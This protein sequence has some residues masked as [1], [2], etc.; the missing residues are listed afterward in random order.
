M[1]RMEG[2][3][4]AA[5]AQVLAGD[6]SAFRSLVER[7]SRTLFRLAFRI[8]ANEQDA[9]DV[10]QES[11]LRAYRKLNSFEMRANFSTWLYRITVN[12]ALDFMR[13]RRKHQAEQ[14]M[15]GSDGLDLLSNL[16]DHTPPPDRL[17]WSSEIQ[18]KLKQALNKLGGKERL[19]FVLRHCE[20][21]SIAEVGQIL[22][23]RESAT[24]HSIFRAVQK[25]RRELR[26]MVNEKS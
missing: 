14:D 22:G 5:V 13:K 10:V 20:G 7:H 19:A 9:E 23:Q 6:Q 24:K 26:P 2:H 3:D 18:N 4:A 17:R 25:L 16:P 11:F 8:T 12:C 1:N 15:E 21:M